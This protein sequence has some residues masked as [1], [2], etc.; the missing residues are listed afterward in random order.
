MLTVCIYTKIY[1]R[2][3]IAAYP[4]NGILP[5]NQM[6]DYNDTQQCGWSSKALDERNQTPETM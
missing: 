5:S 4:Y 1:T 2:M 6:K 3:F